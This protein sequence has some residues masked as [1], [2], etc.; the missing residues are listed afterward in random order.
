MML[1]SSEHCFSPVILLSCMLWNLHSPTMTTF[2][3]G[4]RSQ[5]T[6]LSSSLLISINF[7]FLLTKQLFFFFFFPFFEG[8]HIL[9]KSWQYC[10]I[11]PLTAFTA[12][13]DFRNLK[14]HCHLL[15]DSPLQDPSP[16]INF[17]LADFSI[18]SNTTSLDNLWELVV[19]LPLWKMASLPLSLNSLVAGLQTLSSYIFAKALSSF[20][21]FFILNKLLS[22]SSNFLFLLSFSIFSFLHINKNN[23]KTSLFNLFINFINYLH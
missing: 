16:H 8:N 6:P 7:T 21:L 22:F 1:C 14:F 20:K 9:I 4:K 23:K 19:P 18:I 15:Y 2:T 3:T 17:S 11:N 10:D 5:N 12:Y 13:L